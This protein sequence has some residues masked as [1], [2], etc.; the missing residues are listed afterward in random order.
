[1]H[2][3]LTTAGISA[4]TGGVV[5]FALWTLNKLSED[6]GFLYLVGG[7]A[8]LGGVLSFFGPQ[9]FKAFR[10]SLKSLG[11]REFPFTLP[12]LGTVTI[13]LGNPQRASA[14]KIFLEMTTR[15]V[16]Q[17]LEEEDG[18]IRAAIKSLYEFFNAVREELKSMPA[19]PP[20]ASDGTET[21]E[22]IAQNM[23][24][25][26]VRPYL[27]RWHP[28]LDA[29]EQA[30]FAEH[31]WPLKYAC[32]ED[33]A[34]MRKAAAVY[35]L[36]LGETANILRIETYVPKELRPSEGEAQVV[37]DSRPNEQLMEALAEFDEAFQGALSPEV[38][39]AA[40][41]SALDLTFVSTLLSSEAPIDVCIRA[42]RSA[43][44]LLRHRLGRGVPGGN[45][46]RGEKAIQDTNKHLAYV[47]GELHGQAVPDKDRLV[48]RIDQCANEL[49][50]VARGGY[51]S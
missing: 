4:L 3:R 43:S 19:T 18:T 25:S 33:L 38:R 45:T 42:A 21:L 31:E 51:K 46:N 29:W 39:E 50:A 15:T 11:I 34:K 6:G 13:P 22:S 44:S 12:G 47:I 40:W 24:N 37:L 5:G 23:L 2:S 35:A 9:L 27:S 8:L 41:R 30:G 32:L 20:N 10:A 1:M 48:T 49:E 28:R 17:P 26:V 14:R 36:L 16:L 7:W